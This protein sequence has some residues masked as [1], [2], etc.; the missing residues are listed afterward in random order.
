[1]ENNQLKILFLT[2]VPSPYR[3]DFF[4][5]L[6]KRCD[7]TVLY[8]KES[9]SERDKK[10]ISESKNTYK[11][12][13]LKGINTGVDNSFCPSVIK[14][15]NNTFDA[16]IICGNASPTEMFA[17]QWCILKKIPYCLEGDGAFLNKGNKLK[18]K[19]KKHLISNACLFFSSCKELD[20]YYIN[21]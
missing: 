4:G 11:S 15:L 9:S 19:I 8:Q 18:D 17:I 2:N 21:Y 3:V 10:W 5:E 1:M 20:K 13:F 14:Y 7:L 6:G 16:I 12:V